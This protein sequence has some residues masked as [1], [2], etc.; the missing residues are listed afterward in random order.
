MVTSPRW[1]GRGCY[2]VWCTSACISSRWLTCYFFGGRD[3]LFV[4]I[5]EGLEWV[6]SVVYASPVNSIK[7][8]LW[9][10]LRDLS[11]NIH[12]PWLVIGDFHD[13]LHTSEKRGGRFDGRRAA[14]F[15]ARI[16]DCGLQD[17]GFQDAPYTFARK[18]HEAIRAVTRA[19]QEFNSKVFGNLFHR[20]RVLMAR[21]KGIQLY[22]SH[23]HSPYLVNLEVQL[24]DEYRNVLRQ[25]ELFWFQ[26]S[27]IKW[28][29][30]RDRV[31]TFFHVTTLARRNKNRIDKLCLRTDI[32]TM[33]L[34]VI[35]GEVLSYF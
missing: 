1:H 6:C 28:L 3:P 30:G 15:H 4:G 20:K 9:D 31:M 19:A 34:D 16:G 22:L 7:A 18:F 33:D 27:R 2:F 21:L 32:W 5:A 25:E 29:Q 8:A 23:R 11:S 12:L 13:Y 26:K 10:Y 17:L 24:A 35:E 14:L